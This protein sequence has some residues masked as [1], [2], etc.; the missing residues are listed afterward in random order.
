MILRFIVFH[1]DEPIKTYE[2]NESVITIGRLPENTISIANMGV[3]RRHSKIERTGNQT[4]IIS[5][6]N[7]LNGTFVNEQKVKREQLNVG[8]KITIG[9][10]SVLFDDII[11][12]SDDNSPMPIL[13]ESEKI[14]DTEFPG[15]HA[16][17]TPAN[18]AIAGPVL[19][20]TGSHT[21]YSLEKNLLSLG[22]SE[23]DDIQVS[24][25]MIGDGHVYVQK[26]DDGF[27]IH[28]SKPVSRLKVNN[29]K[30]TEH[31][32]GHKDLIEIGG[33][34]FRYMEKG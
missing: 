6:L 4:F 31:H 29:K 19:I 22:A 2:F 32:L 26:R 30:V 27:W 10:Y 7:S 12:D 20:D 15:K 23:N 17:A 34:T 9:K 21:T 25:F 11:E 18:K 5:D 13:V 28:S 33:N 8:D 1:N 16:P 3:S 14:G 24:G